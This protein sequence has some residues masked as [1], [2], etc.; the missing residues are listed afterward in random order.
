[1]TNIILTNITLTNFIGKFLTIYFI[2]IKHTMSVISGDTVK[3]SFHQGDSLHFSHETLGRQCMANAVAAAVY[4]TML[5]VH[6]WDTSSLDRIL[7]AGDDLYRRRCNN[8][9]EYLQLSDIHH[10]EVL[11]YDRYVIN[12]NA[13]MTGLVDYLIDPSPPFFTLEQAICTMENIQQW[14][15]GVLTLADVNTGSSVL[16][17]VKQGNYYIFDSHSRDVFGNIISNGTSVLLHMR[18]HNGFIRYIKTIADALN[19]TQF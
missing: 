14:T 7:L 19:A 15:Y 11:F 16:L 4:A 13:P 3:G 8:Q 12:G 18:T 17:C 6:L 2:D 10:T 9:Y 5:P 1:M